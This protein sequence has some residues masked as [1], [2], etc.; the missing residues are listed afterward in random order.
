V[1]HHIS[2]V[3]CIGVLKMLR[4]FVYDVDMPREEMSAITGR[5]GGTEISCFMKIPVVVRFN[6]S[7]IGG[8][9]Q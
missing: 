3:V 2:I 5:K 7:F 1:L 9:H 4:H 8:I 6:N